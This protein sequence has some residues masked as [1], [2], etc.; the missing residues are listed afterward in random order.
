[1]ILLAASILVQI[2]CVLHILNTG[3]D[4]IWIWIVLLFSAL[5]CCAYFAFQVMPELF[6]PGS[7]HARRS[8]AKQSNDPLRKLKVAEEKLALVDTAANRAELG[9]AYFS[10][11]AFGKAADEYRK[12]LDHLRGRDAKIETRLG[13]AL[14]ENGEFAQAQALVDRMDRPVAVGE[15]DRLD[16]LRARILVELGQKDEAAALYSDIVTRVPGEEARCRYSALLLE[17][18]RTAEARQMLEAVEQQVKHAG[19]TRSPDDSAMVD[20]AMGEL[21]SLRNAFTA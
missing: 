3:R 21:R 1:M 11:K 2:L 4:R 14:F 15:A 19:G 16:F 10:M 9:D 8:F 5:G 17:L 6:G 13:W 7:R 20:W 12:A 18:G